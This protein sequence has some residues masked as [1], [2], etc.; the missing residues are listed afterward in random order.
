M[1]SSGQVFL[2]LMVHGKRFTLY[3]LGPWKT[4]FLACY[5]LFD[6]SGASVAGKEKLDL[7]AT[8]GANS[9]DIASA[10][11]DEDTHWSGGGW[12]ES[13]LREVGN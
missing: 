10:K 4:L 12:R 9:R 7:C 3:R 1:T 13:K 8:S 2:L 5:G 11:K 6:Q